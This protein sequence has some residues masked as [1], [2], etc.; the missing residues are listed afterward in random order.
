[1]FVKWVSK[2]VIEVTPNNLGIYKYSVYI[3]SSLTY[4]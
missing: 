2:Y 4:P 3:S 1:M